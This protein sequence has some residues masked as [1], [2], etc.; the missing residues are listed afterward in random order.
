MLL[1]SDYRK[2]QQKNDLSDEGRFFV[3]VSFVV[4]LTDV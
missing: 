3:D 1:H 2:A 4:R